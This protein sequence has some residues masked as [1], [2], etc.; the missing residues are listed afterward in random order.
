MHDPATTLSAPGY[1][2]RSELRVAPEL[3][4]FVEEEALPGTGVDAR[5]FWAGLSALV[6]E[7][8]PRNAA[9]LARRD[10]LQARIDA[11]H[12]ERRDQPHDREAYKA[13]LGE[14]GYLLPEG[15]DFTIETANVDPEIA[16]RGRAAA[17]GAD[18]QRPLRAQRRER[19]LG[20]PLRLPLRHR[21]DGQPAAGRRLRPRP[22]RPRRR[23]G[24]GVPRRGLPARRHQPCR[25][26]AL[27]RARRRAARRRHAARRAREVRRLPRPSAGARG[28]AAPQQRP[29]RRAGL[30]P[31]PPDR[32]PRPGRARRRAAGER[33]HGDHGLRGLG[34]L[35]RRRGQGRRLPQLA[36][37]DAGRP[38]GDLREG[39]PDAHPQPQPRPDASPPP[40]AA[41]SR[42]RAAR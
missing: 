8:G 23:A 14:I 29:A 35:R 38:R 33:A 32:Q 18:H 36:R 17:R 9:L 6:H 20:E 19:A 31:H 41:R 42:S 22:R 4:A 16:T 24:A 2:D 26:A 39:R 11:W 13:F 5:A 1:V 37:A 30:R 27:P 25:R 7:L 15:G 21:R 12:V 10:E 3:A 34:R 40:T 28:G